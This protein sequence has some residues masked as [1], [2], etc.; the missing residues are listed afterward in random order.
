MRGLGAAGV[1][2]AARAAAVRFWG[3]QRLCGA[4]AWRFAGERGSAFTPIG[5]ACDGW[6]SYGCRPSQIEFPARLTKVSEVRVV[7]WNINFRGSKAAKRQ[8]VC[9]ANW[10]RT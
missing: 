3:K 6:R 9:C 8:E 5:S 4:P 7:S 1:R 10:P 2:A